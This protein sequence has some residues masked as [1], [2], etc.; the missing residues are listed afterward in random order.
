MQLETKGLV[1]LEK[2]VGESDRLVTVLTD[3]EGVLHAFAQQAKKI[4]SSKLS[5]TQLFS[6]S[7][8]SIF[9]GRD[10]YIIDDAQPIE[11]FFDLRKDIER[12]SLAQY[13]CELAG[14]LAPQEAEAGDFLRLMLNALH[15][16]SKGTRPNDLLKAIVEMRMLSLAGYMPNLICCSGC[17]C[18][19]ADQMAFLPRSGLIYCGDCYKPSQEQAILLGRGALTGMR[20]II[21][22][23]FEKLFSF[24][25]SKKGLKQLSKASECFTLCTLERSF[26]TLDFYRQMKTEQ[27]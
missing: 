13:F 10:K 22:S 14:A 12:L 8:L 27:E 1:I 7:R 19:E 23:D 6:Y 21:Y 20:H 17:S 9:K 11:V 25:L 15:F 16:L 5:A 26:Q 2:C 4:K 3:R 18:Y 24:T